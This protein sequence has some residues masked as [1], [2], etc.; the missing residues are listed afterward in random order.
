MEG[1]YGV[2]IDAA[3]GRVY[4]GNYDNGTIGFA[5][6]D[7]SGGGLLNTAGATVDGPSGLAI[8]PLGGRIYWA[9][10]GND[11][12][13]YASFVGGAQGQVETTG[14]TLDA[15]GEVK[16][17]AKVAYEPTGA[18]KALKRTRTITLRKRRGS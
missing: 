18:A 4:W 16:V 13:V 12:I 11:T 8:D 5:N 3:A 2:A 14:A 6:L 17:R 1:P 9:N 7:G 10:A 15:T